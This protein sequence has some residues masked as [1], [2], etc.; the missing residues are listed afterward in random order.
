MKKR[1][2]SCRCIRCREVGNN[3]S[4]C[5]Q[6]KIR[7]YKGSGATEI[8]I[9]MESQDEKTIMG[10]LRLRLGDS[11]NNDKPNIFPELKGAALIRE[12]HVYGQLIS[13]NLKLLNYYQ[14]NGIK[15]LKLLYFHWKIFRMFF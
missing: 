6:L 3:T 15:N 7:K 1:G 2:L 10:F 8:F 11:D 14:F 13:T 9:S 12:L 4:V 5:A